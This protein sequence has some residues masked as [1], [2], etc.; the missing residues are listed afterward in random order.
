MYR[1]LRLNIIAL[2]LTLL[3]IIPFV[4]NS[5]TGFTLQPAAAAG[6]KQVTE[7]SVTEEPSADP[8]TSV[9]TDIPTVPPT[10][11]P[12]QVPATVAPAAT[13][14]TT[15]V[16]QA[17]DVV[18]APPVAE[19]TEPTSVP[20]ATEDAETVTPA[21][22]EAVTPAVIETVTSEATEAVTPAATET[23][24]PETTETVI[25]EATE[26][27]APEVTL[28]VTAE[29]LPEATLEVTDEVL[30]EATLEATAEVLP[31]AT[32]EATAEVLPP[33]IGVTLT[34]NPTGMEFVIANAGGDMT[35]ARAYDFIP[36]STFASAPTG[37]LAATPEVGTPEEPPE[38]EATATV[39][40]PGEFMLLEGESLTLNGGF[41]RPSLV[42]DG[43]TYQ[44][45]EDDPCLPPD[46]PVIEVTS[47][48]EFDTGITFIITNSGAPMYE[49][50]NYSIVASDGSLLSGTFQL[51]TDE[52]ISV[53]AGY[54]R[55]EL[56][57]GEITSLPEAN[58][59]APAAISGSVWYDVDN[60]GARSAVDPGIAGASVTLTDATGAYQTTDTV[61]DGSYA[62]TMLPVGDYTISVDVAAVSSDYVPSIP[63]DAVAT[64]QAESGGVYVADF[65][66]MATPS[67]SISGVVWLETS[68]FGVFDE[69]EPGVSGAL[70][71]L[72]D[73]GG[74]VVA[75]APVN[76]VTG[77][78]Q[79]SE[80]LA[81]SYRVQ[82]DQSTLFTPNGV[83]FNRDETFDYETL[84][85]VTTDQA[86]TDIDFGIVGTF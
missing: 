38:P 65:A 41:G 47:I 82:L 31:E 57:T 80:V 9:P 72:V 59:D 18:T 67:A 43:I 33:D 10:A 78:Y 71:D 5:S 20:T 79:F 14:T 75:V 61:S 13:N 26:T 66:F 40:P 84:V 52:Q 32:L 27:I 62:F 48:C 58:C 45:A 44:P 83:T 39:E 56:T 50:Q 86:L 85:T 35:A 4:I 15:P 70:V 1:H 17:T 19:T 74:N 63:A 53:D 64:V 28:E 11:P 51:T 2:V 22:T 36:D 21:V 3:V 29:V 77:A 12:T 16:D 60:D 37:D 25:P 23:I 49:E 24:A 81:G 76:A 69:N 7:E 55:P 54:D 73:G 6:D 46:P 42:I 34:C 30:P 8:P 68:N